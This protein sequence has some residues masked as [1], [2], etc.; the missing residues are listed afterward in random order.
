[1]T[2]HHR[3]SIF[4]ALKVLIAVGLLV[5]V[6]S[7]V[8]WRDYVVAADG[9]SYAVLA[10]RRATPDR[11]AELEVAT[12]VLGRRSRIAP[13]E[14]FQP[15]PGT[16]QLRRPGFAT[17]VT[18]LRVPLLIA[19]FAVY[20]SNMLVIATRWWL[21]L[22]VVDIHLSLWEAV[23]LSFL[24]A[25]FSVVVP[26]TVSGD[27]VKAYYAAKH[28]PAKAAALV[29]VFMDRA[30]GLTELTLM[31]TIVLA[32]VAVTGLAPLESLRLPAGL[33]A[34]LVVVLVAA[35]AFLFSPALR[36]R[37]RL[38]RLYGRL[39]L[40]GHLA[41]AG[42]AI[43]QYR[44]NIRRLVEAMG[45]T[46]IGQTL[47]ICSMILM[48]QSLSLA[49]PWTSYF[50]YVPVIFA[51]ASVPLTPGGLGLVEKF[52]VVF[53]VTEAVSASEVV[54]LALLVRLMPMLWSL[55]GA[56]VAVRGARV[57]AAMAI[58]AELGLKD[59]PANDQAAS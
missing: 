16:D 49:T 17:T 13:A 37:L 46:L 36:H 28:T 45:I 40:A 35:F 29:S 4:V 50:L 3:R 18:N 20:V 12:G 34:V 58:Q 41:V 9:R 32:V 54:A 15:I 6:L 42:K 19:A 8:H 47:W 7:G 52:F 39:P 2:P 22:H 1:M 10:E 59:A 57:P 55:P 14:E 5:W 48:G 23:R 51:I 26:G 24:G 56:V 21:L 33:L 44:G 11:P 25:Y 27:L 38:D 30:M 43:R 53:F 31:A